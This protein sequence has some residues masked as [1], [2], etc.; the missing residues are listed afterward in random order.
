MK[1]NEEKAIVMF[2]RDVSKKQQVANIVALGL[3]PP[4]ELK[5][6]LLN[7]PYLSKKGK[8]VADKIYNDL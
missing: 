4:I 7:N 6:H 5:E 3:T 2:Q 8:Q 1:I